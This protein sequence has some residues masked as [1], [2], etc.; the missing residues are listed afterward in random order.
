M[1]K[2]GILRYIADRSYKHASRGI[3]RV[4]VTDKTKGETAGQIVDGIV[5]SD[6]AAAA[7]DPLHF[8]G[9]V[10]VVVGPQT[11]S[12]AVL[13]SNVVQDYQFGKVAGVGDA[14]RTRQ[15]GGT[16]NLTLPHSGLTLAYPRLVLTRPS[17][18][19]GAE[20]MHPDLPLADDP[21]RPRAIIEDLLER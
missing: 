12:S 3:K 17:G 5:P 11:Y 2:D 20:F 9:D 16:R 21:L 1:W 8:E 15:S 19:A 4:L 10:Y 13:F 6:T 7:D 18:K 14:A